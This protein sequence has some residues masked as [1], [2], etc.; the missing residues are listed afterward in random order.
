MSATDV[1]WAILFYFAVITLFAA[2]I[3]AAFLVIAGK[4]EPA[5]VLAIIWL[6]STIAFS[7]AFR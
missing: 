5:L 2:P 3:V 1:A 4:F 7:T 6:G